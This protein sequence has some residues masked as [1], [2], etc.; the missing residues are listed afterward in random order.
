MRYSTSFSP[1][2][3]GPKTRIANGSDNL[4]ILLESLGFVSLRDGN[5]HTREDLSA[6]AGEPDKTFEGLRM[7]VQDLERQ[8]CDV[9]RQLQGDVA[10]LASSLHGRLD[11]IVLSISAPLGTK[12]Q[13]MAS[14]IAA[15][16]NDNDKRHTETVP[17][18]LTNIH[19]LA[20]QLYCKLNFLCNLAVSSLRKTFNEFALWGEAARLC[21]R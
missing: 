18:H 12:S 20:R 3:L 4:E 21:P 7:K 13:G 14:D 10:Q 15:R 16:P 2:F 9:Q 1:A 11:E 17:D 5:A 6:R 8:L 19:K